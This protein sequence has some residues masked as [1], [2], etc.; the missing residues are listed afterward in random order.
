MG[1]AG[2]YELWVRFDLHPCSAWR[3]VCK[4]FYHWQTN[5]N[6]AELHVPPRGQVNSCQTTDSTN[7]PR[8][9]FV[10]LYRHT[11]D[12]AMQI[13]F[14]CLYLSNDKKPSS[15]Y[16][17]RPY[18]LTA[19]LVI[20]DCCLMTSPAVFEILCSNWDHQFDSLTFQGHMTSSVTWPFDSP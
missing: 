16:D 3:M 7:R 13:L 17:S 15:R 8:S 1:W 11:H 10:L 4:V 19:N 14:Y 6:S 20:S 12:A 9:G 18:C 5:D 2:S